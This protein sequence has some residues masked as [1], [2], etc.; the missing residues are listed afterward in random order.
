MASK[1]SYTFEISVMDAANLRVSKNYW[2]WYIEAFEN[3]QFPVK[4]VFATY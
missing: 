2:M 4:K 1:Y 3:N